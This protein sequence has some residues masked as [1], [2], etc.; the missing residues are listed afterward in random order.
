MTIVGARF[1]PSRRIGEAAPRGGARRPGGQPASQPDLVVDDEPHRLGD[2][3]V[4]GL[5]GDQPVHPLG[6]QPV[7]GMAL[8]GGAQL[9]QVHQLAGV[10]RHGEPDPVGQ[11][12][13]VGGLGRE[14]GRGRVQPGRASMAAWKRPASPAS[15]TSPGRS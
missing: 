12:D 7:G 8:G 14:P 5:V 1:R 13:G 4:P 6:D 10:H 15:A 9:G 11:A 2:A 3:P